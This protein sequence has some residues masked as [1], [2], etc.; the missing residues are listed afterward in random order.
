MSRFR[1]KEHFE[2]HAHHLARLLAE[3]FENVAIGLFSLDSK[4]IILETEEI[5]QFSISLLLKKA[6][7]SQ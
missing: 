1:R 7:P 3:A 6:H 2:A 5:L 4:R